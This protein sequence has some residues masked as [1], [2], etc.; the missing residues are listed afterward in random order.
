MSRA[1][2]AGPDPLLEGI[3]QDCEALD[4]ITRNGWT[5]QSGGMRTHRDAFGN[6]SLINPIIVD[7]MLH[8]TLV[9]E[10][11]ERAAFELA[12]ERLHWGMLR[13]RGRI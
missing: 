5:M 2:W 13:S 1:R 4:G 6:L 7:Y 3:R 11:G 8:S 12:C 9:A 10:I